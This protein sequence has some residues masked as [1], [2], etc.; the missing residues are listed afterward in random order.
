MVNRKEER[1]FLMVLT[2]GFT[3][4]NH[5]NFSTT[6]IK[7]LRGIFLSVIEQVKDTTHYAIIKTLDEQFI[8][9]HGDIDKFRLQLCMSTAS[10]IWLDEWGSY[11]GIHR[12][13]NEGDNSYRVRIVLEVT[14]PKV[15]K[16]S[17]ESWIR[18]Y[19]NETEEKEYTEEDV[20]IIEPWK[21]LG[22]YSQFGNLSDTA[23]MYSKDYY[24]HAVID[25]HVPEDT[26]VSSLL[27]DLV[28]RI[29]AAGV[30]A[31]FSRQLTFSDVVWD[32]NKGNY[33]NYIET[34]HSVETETSFKLNHGKQLSHVGK[35]SGSIPH[36]DIVDKELLTFFD[37]ND[38][39]DYMPKDY[40]ESI[41]ITPYS[42][43]EEILTKG[44]ISPLDS[45]LEVT[46]LD[47]FPFKLDEDGNYVI[48]DYEETVDND[49]TSFIIDEYSD[50]C[51]FPTA[52][53]NTQVFDNKLF[54]IRD[55]GDIS[56]SDVSSLVNDDTYIETSILRKGTLIPIQLPLPTTSDT[57]DGLYIVTTDDITI[58]DSSDSFNADVTK[59]FILDDNGDLTPLPTSIS[60]DSTPF[61]ISEEETYVTPSNDLPLT[62]VYSKSTEKRHLSGSQYIWVDYCRQI[63][64]SLDFNQSHNIF[65]SKVFKLEETEYIFHSLFDGS[66]SSKYHFFDI[67]E[68]GDFEPKTELLSEYDSTWEMIQNALSEIEVSDRASKVNDDNT[69]ETDVNYRGELEPS[70]TTLITLAIDKVK[71]AELLR[72]NMNDY[73]VKYVCPPIQVLQYPEEFLRQYVTYAGDSSL[74]VA[75]DKS[76]EQDNHEP[77]FQLKDDS[78][79]TESTTDTYGYNV[80]QDDNAFCSE[81]ELETNDNLTPRDYHTVFDVD[82][83]G[84]LTPSYTEPAEDMLL[85]SVFYINSDNDIVIKDEQSS[86]DKKLCS[87]FT[88]TTNNELTPAIQLGISDYYQCNLFE[89]VN[90]KHLTTRENSPYYKFYDIEHNIEQLCYV[91]LKVLEQDYI[92]LNYDIHMIRNRKFDTNSYW[93]NIPQYEVFNSKDFSVSD[94]KIPTSIIQDTTI[95]AVAILPNGEQIPIHCPDVS[96]DIEHSVEIAN[97]VG[98][99]DD[100]TMYVFNRT[101]L[102][103]Y[104]IKDLDIESFES[105]YA[106]QY[107]PYMLPMTIEINHITN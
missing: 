37:I 16:P 26:S 89:Q 81:F 82:E 64:L 83:Y 59:E 17:M 56:P 75:T 18:E 62:R 9:A 61:F 79:I 13:Y 27:R 41:G 10:G 47:S 58:K 76:I 25:V 77:Y 96:V 24:T 3:M 68:L 2:V 87:T 6:F 43:L 95:I 12:K 1:C 74:A 78:I 21:N 86:F 54:T 39:G 51:L 69:L 46:T 71:E 36:Y 105:K 90:N 14:R 97:F 102:F 34:E 88:V 8:Q 103:Y 63:D 52:D 80:P 29:K 28:N 55:F 40:S 66:Q 33:K 19:L 100:N 49:S 31:Y 84:N 94:I 11:F 60:L 44:E 98:D 99:T 91:N 32:T 35:L 93:S 70:A 57:T 30:K 23:L 72:L 92:S 101:E 38:N 20:Y 67:D 22:R 50:I 65:N 85:G 15:T 4:Q 73:L 7:N 104:D 106:Y 53:N 5:M 107:T 42:E 48:K 45:E